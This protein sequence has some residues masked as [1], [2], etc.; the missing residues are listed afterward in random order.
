MMFKRVYI[1]I[2]IVLSGIRVCS[3]QNAEQAFPVTGKPILTV[4]A[5]YK[6]GL[7]NVNQVSGFN[8]DR[9]FVGY[10]AFLPKGFSAKVVLNVETYKGNEGRTRFGS[11]LK[12]AQVNWVKGGFSTSLGLVNLMQFSE[13][14]EAWGHRYI[15]RSFQE[16]YGFAYCED[17]GIVAGYDFSRFI[18]ADIAFTNGEGRKFKN[19]DN[20]YRYGG[21][22]TLRPLEGLLLRA[23]ADVYSR[24]DTSNMGDGV[25]KDQYSLALFAGYT[26][27]YFS[28]GGEFNKSFNHRFAS[29]RDLTGYSVYATVP[30]YKTLQF[31]GR[32]D[33]LESDHDWNRQNDGHAIIAG[34]DYQ[35][36]RY[37]RVSPNFQSWKGA[38]QKRNNYLLI[39]VELKI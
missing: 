31:Y 20:N 27:R 29:G 9:A 3:A 14:E 17:I 26:H 15:F 23:Y 36:I 7:G 18:S 4:F 35:P 12:N 19:G 10:E 2:M 34:L 37:F 39:S 22:V 6:A 8:L 5:N 16:E 1:L 38:G 11:Y 32:F 25:L 30:L 28:I 13:Q 24:P 33:L 21:G